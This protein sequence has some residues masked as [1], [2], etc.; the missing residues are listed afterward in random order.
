[1]TR[2]LLPGVHGA[3]DIRLDLAVQGRTVLNGLFPFEGR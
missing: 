1:M 3:A 2:T